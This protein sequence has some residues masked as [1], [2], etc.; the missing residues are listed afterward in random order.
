[1]GTEHLVLAALEEPSVE[2]LLGVTLQ[3]AR[4]ALQSLDRS[5][6]ATFGAGL[7][8]EVAPAPT[9]ALPKEPKFRDVMR[10][11]R[12][13]MTPAA[14]KVLEDAVRPNRRKTQVTADQLVNRIVALRSPDPSAALLGALGVNASDILQRL[15]TTAPRN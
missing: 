2:T 11:G 3:Q 1:M 13:R 14:K 5:A 12:L 15:D 9:R 6:L 4:D 10:Q 8:L 7:D